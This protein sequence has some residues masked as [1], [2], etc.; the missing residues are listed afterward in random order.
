MTHS[1]NAFI[2]AAGY[3]SRLRPLTDTIPKPLLPCMGV[4]LIDI[5][6]HQLRTQGIQ[7]IYINTHHLPDKFAHLSRQPQELA[8]GKESCAAA[9]GKESCAAASGKK[10]PRAQ[11][12]VTLLHEP[13]LLGSAGFVR[14]LD[15]LNTDL[16]T[17]NGD[18]I[19]DIDFAALY[20]THL[21]RK[22]IATLALL[23]AALPNTRPVYMHKRTS[24]RP[25]RVHAAKTPP[26]QCPH[27]RLCASAKCRVLATD[28]GTR[29]HPHQHRLATCSRP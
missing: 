12:V 7:H 11:R 5:T 4:P 16:I 15:Q 8:S 9:S 18:I 23:P 24:H 6:L 2:L 27:F 10:P 20:Q 21:Q 17:Y 3:G 13:T 29:I 22:A 25:R 26:C 14:N 1:V 28:R 19:S